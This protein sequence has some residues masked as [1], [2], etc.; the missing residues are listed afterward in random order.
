MNASSS[1]N[2]LTIAGSDSSGGA[3]IQADLKTFSALGAYGLSVITALTA[4]NTHGVHAVQIVDTEFVKAQL[5]AVF[6]DI[7]INSVKIGMIANASIALAIAET[8]QKYRPSYVVLDPVMVSKS[9]HR[10]LDDNAIEIIKSH[11]LPMANL[12]TP[13]LPEAAV[14]LNIDEAINE[15]DMLQQGMALCNLGAQAVLV[16]GGHLKCVDSPDWLI[17]R[18][19]NI[20]FN[21]SRIESRA[22]HGT[23]CTL[24][25]A[26]AVKLAK[27]G[28]LNLAI[29]ESKKYITQA[30]RYAKY[31]NVGS[32]IGPT[33]H[34]HEWW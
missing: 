10:L 33:H 29:D 31:L 25:A 14:L 30:I 8:L 3:G 16:K 1:I 12:I 21:A 28:Q 6:D 19:A 13:N 7:K 34:F 9:G 4:Q 2:V 15:K 24:S 20:K 26:I 23:G 11:L 5:K 17:S 32:G 18:T 22:T 27:T